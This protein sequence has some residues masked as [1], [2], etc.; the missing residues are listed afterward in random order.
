VWCGVLLLGVGVTLFSPFDSV[1]K[2][3][4]L[5]NGIRLVLAFGMFFVVQQHPAPA[6]MKLKAVVSA[7]LGFSL[8]TTAVALLQMGYWDGWLPI[9]LPAVLT[10][11]KEVANTEQGREIFALYLGDTGSHT[12]SGTLAMQALLAWLV[13][14]YAKR[15]WL[16]WAAWL[17]FGLLAVILIRISV[18]NTILGLFLAIFVLGILRRQKLSDP[19]RSIFRFAVVIVVGVVTLYALLY[20]APDTYF[21]ER[22]RQAVPQFENGKLVISRASNIYGRFAYWANALEMFASAPI[23]GN[24]F[25]SFQA[26]ARDSYFYV[27]AVHAH[28]SYVQSLAELGVLGAIALTWL[29]LNI[30][31][32]LYRTRQYFKLGDVG[33]FWWEFVT[34]SCVFL[35]FTMIFSNTFW[36][37]NYIA[38]RMIVLGIL[39]GLVKE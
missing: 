17:Y 11:F 34:G 6:E 30:G 2:K 13:G 25:Y 32:Y 16:K 23:I 14:G 29:M 33:A 15:P 36:S 20:V 37:P 19:V 27:P 21:I 35:A 26:I 18:R 9:H 7:V 8:I 1:T 24:G 31:Q 22:I 3:D 28:N 39:V 38:F 12:W 10:T 4:A 5:I